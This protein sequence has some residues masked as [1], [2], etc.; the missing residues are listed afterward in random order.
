[1][2]E[3]RY[4]ERADKVYL[5]LAALFITALVSCNLIANK[6]VEID[7]GFKTFVVSAGI[8][9]YP[10]TFLVTDLLSEVYG[11]R[12]ASLV[13]WSGLLAS[14]FVLF[15]LWLGHLFPAIPNSPVGNEA[16]DQV[17]QNSWKVILSSMLAY[18]SAQLVDVKLYHFWKNL[19]K[20]R[21][22]WI[23]N[24]FSTL[25]SQFVDTV[26]VVGILFLGSKS[27]TELSSLVFDGWLFKALTA[28][29][30]T[31]PMYAATYALK[32]YL[33]LSKHEEV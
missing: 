15:V 3:T 28:L 31:L 1:M 19:T 16:Y 5:L 12:K 7:L 23:R 6:F 11:Q 9:P 4:K 10:L 33:G 27:Y 14:I 25:L 13:V 21:H 24:N 17:F 18:L 22:L 30:D 29:L 32:R 20:G 2:D 26:L 8:L